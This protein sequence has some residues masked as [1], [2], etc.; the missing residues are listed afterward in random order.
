MDNNT[1]NKSG[2]SFADD[3]LVDITGALF[4]GLLFLVI[5]FVS[6]FILLKIYDKCHLFEANQK[7]G[8]W[9]VLLVVILIISYVIGHVFFRA[10]IIEP[11]KRDIR[12]RINGEI[13]KCRKRFREKLSYEEV[14]RELHDQIL[15]FLATLKD[16][17][18]YSQ[19][20]QKQMPEFYQA[21]KMFCE[22]ATRIDIAPSAEYPMAILKVLFPEEVIRIQRRKSQDVDSRCW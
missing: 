1:N 2:F 9:W 12:R 6:V 7:G 17:E 4:P 19:K 3:L 22:D 13:K 15:A 14:K 20:K 11:D 8:L 18:V 10:D 21:L 16:F 5:L